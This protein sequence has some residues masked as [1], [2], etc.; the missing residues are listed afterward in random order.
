MISAEDALAAL[1]KEATA[2]VIDRKFS[3][4]EECFA[5]ALEHSQRSFGD[6][7]P[8][9]ASLLG[10][11]ARACI[12]QGKLDFAETLLERQLFLYEHERG[13]QSLLPERLTVLQDL[14]DMYSRNGKSDE[15]DHTKAKAALFFTE[16]E[17]RLIEMESRAQANAEEEEDS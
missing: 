2:H 8:R 16:I 6:S 4:A 10:H 11:L 13:L 9:T 14:G 15:A 17:K 5:L 1:V 3:L 7:D 12:E